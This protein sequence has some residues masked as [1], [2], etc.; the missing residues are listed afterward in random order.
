VIVP[1]KATFPSRSVPYTAVGVP[2]VS[3]SSTRPSP[4][5]SAR[6]EVTVCTSPCA[7]VSLV[8]TF[9]PTG[10][11]IGVWLMSFSAR[12]SFTANVVTYSVAE[13]LASGVPSSV[14]V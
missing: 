2:T 4:S 8:S 13:S 11:F 3:A 6:A 9:P 10:T 5:V 7:S 12:V 1:A 14:A